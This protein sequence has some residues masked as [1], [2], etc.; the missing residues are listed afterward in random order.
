MAN[1]H[2]EVLALS[3]RNGSSLADYTNYI[4]GQSVRDDIKE[5][6]YNYRRD[7]VAFINI[8]L[9]DTAPDNYQDLQTLVS[10]MDKA[11]KRVDARTARKFIGSLPNELPLEAQ[12]GIV[13]EFVEE[14]FM[15]R[16]LCT[17]AAIHTGI[18]HEDPA[19][20]NPHVHLI[21]S[22]RQLNSEGF[23]P[24]K[25][26]SLDRNENIETWRKSWEDIQNRA[27]ER[28]GLDVRVSRLCLEVQRGYGPTEFY[29][30]LWKMEQKREANREH[31]A[32]HEYVPDEREYV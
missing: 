12:I 26:R 5:K 20:D 4:S 6:T 30:P 10:A 23:A 14:N 8:Y 19:K 3:R 15:G 25:D 11:E 31:F 7:D 16:G 29:V 13:S 17:I 9:P 32:E 18:N 1:F 28:A 27:Y 22:T 21:V 2:L 24:K